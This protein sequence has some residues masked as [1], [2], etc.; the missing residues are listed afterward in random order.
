MCGLRYLNPRPTREEIGLYHPEQY[1]DHAP[2]KERTGFEQAVERFSGLVTQ[3]IMEDFYGYPAAAP[4]G[5]FRRFH[6]VLLWPEKA[7]QVFR[8]RDI[9][10]WI[11]QGRLLDVGVD[12]A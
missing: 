11:G 5:P 9:L 4:P 3:W 8:G 6:K 10:P 1:F 12:R 2:P 7:C